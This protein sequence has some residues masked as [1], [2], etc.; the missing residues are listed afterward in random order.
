[1]IG[2]KKSGVLR[3]KYQFFNTA[4][5]KLSGFFDNIIKRTTFVWAANRRDNAERTAVRT[6]ISYF[7]VGPVGSGGDDPVKTIRVGMS[8]GVWSEL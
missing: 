3:Y 2:A 6:S 5:C 4:L 7:K 8:F 1:M